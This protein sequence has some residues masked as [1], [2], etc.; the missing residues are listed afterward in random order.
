MDVPHACP[1]ALQRAELK[2]LH[3]TLGAPQLAGN[4]ANALLLDKAFQDDALLIAG[5]PPD[6]LGEHHPPVHV[7][8]LRLISAFRCRRPVLARDAL[9][10]VGDGIPGDPQQPGHEGD[11]PPLEA[12][13]MGQRV[14][15][16]F[17]GEIL[18]LG[19]APSAAGD[20]RVDPL[21]VALVQ[22]GKAARIGLGGLDQKPL[23]F[24]AHRTLRC[25]RPWLH[26]STPY[27]GRCP[28]NVTVGEAAS[29]SFGSGRRSYSPGP[30]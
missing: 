21:E 3:R 16:D 30:R 20:E 1:Q 19:A 26:A 2:L 27:N 5:Q 22:L 23:V 28:A 13:E 10:A 6:Q 11:T 24:T 12:A 14:V 25:R 7:G 4:L 29:Q 8:L 18:G 9:P 15:K 17:R